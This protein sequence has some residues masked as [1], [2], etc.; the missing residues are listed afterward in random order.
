MR[1]AARV[2]G[3][4]AVWLW[5]SLPIAL[6]G[7]G[8]SLTGILV[9]A[10]YAKETES[11]AAQSVAQDIANLLS[12]PALA[13][14]AGLA[15]RGSLR[16]YL[17]WLSV[18]AFSAYSYVIYAFT[19]HFGP[20]F[21][22]YVTVLGLSLS[23][24]VGGLASLDA[25]RVKA[26]FDASAPVRSTGA[27]VIVLGSLFALLWL[28]TI[29]PATI[30]GTTPSELV[31]AGLKTNPVHVLDLAVF[32][33]AALVAGALVR[34][35]RALGYVLAPLVLTTVA[36]FGLAIVCIQAVFAARDLDAV[37][38]VAAGMAIV[39][40]VVL[41]QLGRFLRAADDEGWADTRGAAGS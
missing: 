27:L 25:E 32:L 21:L 20:L 35:R 9:D 4:A 29:V 33:P 17:V 18:L 39:T 24:L 37:S 26:S 36:L 22:L 13:A 14:L 41:F 2:Q 19:I 15:A 3:G 5:L 7:I 11:W 31:D 6:L 40:V 16:A 30:E 28:S 12:L 8:G 10:V 23:A 38:G 1:T 34:R